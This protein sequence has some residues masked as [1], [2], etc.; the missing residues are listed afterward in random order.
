MFSAGLPNTKEIK[1]QFSHKLFPKG[2]ILHKEICAKK[3]RIKK[4][5]I[6]L[7]FL[8]ILCVHTK[9]ALKKCFPATSPKSAK[10]G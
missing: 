5:K 7:D 8:S 10:N 2:R 4:I 3:F 6:N 9:K 1:R